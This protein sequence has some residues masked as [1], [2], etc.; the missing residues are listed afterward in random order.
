[1]LSSI[2]SVQSISK[3]GFN[4]VKLSNYLELRYDF[5]T[6]GTTVLDISGKKRHGTVYGDATFI[7]PLTNF[8]NATL[9]KTN[10]YCYSL[11]YSAGGYNN[12]HRIT[13][14]GPFPIQTKNYSISFWMRPITNSGNN[15]MYV[16]EIL[17]DKV[18]LMEGYNNLKT[19]G[20]NC[21]PSVYGLFP[22]EIALNVNTWAHIVMTFDYNT[23]STTS[24][25]NGLSK[26]VQ[27]LDS[28]YFFPTLNFPSLSI[29]RKLNNYS[30]TFS[31]VIADFRIYSKVL[32]ADDALSLYNGIN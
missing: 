6:S 17:A 11:P 9:Q 18:F 21:T 27:P 25:V 14:S 12:N 13:L 4:D 19:Y 16:Y 31:G 15:L 26:I 8:P 30:W 24:Y 28:T 32:T 22:Y 23:L 20:V 3:F 5:S 29:G 1:M 2:S 7:T 10:T